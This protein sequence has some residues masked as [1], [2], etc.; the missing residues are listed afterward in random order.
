MGLHHRQLILTTSMQKYVYVCSPFAAVRRFPIITAWCILMNTP[1]VLKVKYLSLPLHIGCSALPFPVRFVC[2]I[3]H[4][5]G[6]LEE[7]ITTTCAV[8]ACLAAIINHYHISTFIPI[9]QRSLLPCGWVPGV[10]S[11]PW[12][13]LQ[14]CRLSRLPRLLR[15][16]NEKPFHTAL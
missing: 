10:G 4:F 3:L 6:R 7:G 2:P 1:Y 16:R 9:F 14:C 15:Y 5:T 13:G 11:P 12:C 8:A